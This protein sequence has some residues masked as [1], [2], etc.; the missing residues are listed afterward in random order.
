[1]DI[2]TGLVGQKLYLIH[3]LHPIITQIGGTYEYFK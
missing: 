3:A 1:M 2:N